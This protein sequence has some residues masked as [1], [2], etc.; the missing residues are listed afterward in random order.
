MDTINNY[1]KF[2]CELKVLTE[3]TKF[4]GDKKILYYNYIINNVNLPQLIRK[5]EY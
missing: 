1:Y 4:L 3:E 2:E 5:D